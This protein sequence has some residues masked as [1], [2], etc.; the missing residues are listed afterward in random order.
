M[1]S[2]LEDVEKRFEQIGEQLQ[3][4]GLA[5]DQKR[6]RSLMKEYADLQALVGQFREYKK[7]VSSL[8]EN[9]DLLI[10]EKDQ[11][12]RKMILS[13]I[14]E[15]ETAQPRLEE[16]LK[17][18]LLPK[19]PNDDKN[20]IVEIRAGAGGDEASLFAEELFRAYTIFGQNRGWTVT[21]MAFSPGNV[22]GAKEILASISGD[23]VYSVLKYE[24]GVHRVQRVPQTESQGRVH[25]ST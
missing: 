13:E 21:L 22:G 23:K 6:Y 5:D 8:A 14:A 19:D 2:K 9:K 10:N 24:S 25:T 4:P 18:S 17:L 1:F 3:E 12:M 11:E 15:L 7:T 20:V 16:E